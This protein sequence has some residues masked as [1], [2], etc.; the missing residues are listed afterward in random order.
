MKDL[1]YK[2]GGKEPQVDNS[3]FIAK[4]ADVIGDV[5]IERDCSIWFGAVIRGDVNR[6]YIGEGS[7][8]QDNAVL[9]VSEDKNPIEIGENV[10]IGHGC[11]LH[12]CKVGSNSLIGMGST[13][14]D[15]A[16][17]GEFT[18]IG[19]GSLVTENKIIPSGVLCMGRPAKVVRYLTEE[20][21]QGL[22]ES[23]KEYIKVSKEY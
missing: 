7:N 12:G 10:T 11:I 6:I 18:L 3:C 8:V 17:I 22:I 21:K 9:H 5:F 2:F 4:S 23:S 16:Q 19:A 14:L 20:E 1:N 13:I 15:N